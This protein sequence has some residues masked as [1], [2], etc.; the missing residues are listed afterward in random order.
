MDFPAVQLAATRLERTRQF[1]LHASVLAVATLAVTAAVSVRIHAALLP[2]AILSGGEGFVVMCAH[3]T[4]RELLQ[5]LALEPAA[6][7]L[8]VVRLY[9]HRLLKQPA[10]DRLAASINSLIA[11]AEKPGTFCLTDRIALVDDQ[12]RMVARELA[13][14]EIPVQARSVVACVRLL[15]H[16]V[17]SPLFNSRVPVEQLQAT[18]LRIRFGIGTRAVE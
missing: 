8:P 15:T 16:G 12:L 9:A 14:P 3:Y 18:L 10:R 7:D 5:R 11:D 13:T 17:E 6:Q 2:L 4:T 1:M